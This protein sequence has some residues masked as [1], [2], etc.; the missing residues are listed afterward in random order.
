[1]CLRHLQGLDE[2]GLGQGVCMQQLSRGA[3]E[4]CF[5]TKQARAAAVRLSGRGLVSEA[6]GDLDPD[7]LPM[8]HLPSRH[9]KDKSANLQACTPMVKTQDIWQKTSSGLNSGNWH[10][11]EEVLPREKKEACMRPHFY[12]LDAVGAEVGGN[13]SDG[14]RSSLHSLLVLIFLQVAQF[15]SW[16][17]ISTCSISSTSRLPCYVFCICLLT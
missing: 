8:L 3:E 5:Q 7:L 13:K 15:Q 6:W 10:R 2:Q 9:R 12:P 4:L 14:A 16:L 17:Y 11:G 1:M